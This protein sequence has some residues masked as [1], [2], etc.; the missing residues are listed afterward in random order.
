[1]ATALVFLPALHWSNTGS[2]TFSERTGVA[3]ALV[4]LLALLHPEV[5]VAPGAL[6]FQKGP[7]SRR[8]CRLGACT[9]CGAC[10]GVSIAVAWERVPLAERVLGPAVPVLFCLHVFSR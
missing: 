8:R 10:L 7:V 5:L 9:A 4:F 3:A 1:M 2:L 6:P